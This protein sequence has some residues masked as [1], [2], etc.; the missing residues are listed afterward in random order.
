MKGVDAALLLVE[1][2][3]AARRSRA[4]TAETHVA[5]LQKYYAELRERLARSDATALECE[6]QIKH[7]AK[8]AVSAEAQLARSDAANGAMRHA[9]LEHD[10]REPVPMDDFLAALR[11]VQYI[12]TTRAEDSDVIQRAGALTEKHGHLLKT[13]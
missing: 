4:E 5:C 13:P 12:G 10:E 3:M 8:R 7:C 9:M 6:E 11:L 2:E 1:Q